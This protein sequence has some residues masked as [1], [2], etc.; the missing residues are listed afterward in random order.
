MCSYAAILYFKLKKKLLCI[1]NYMY[2]K[3]LKRFFDCFISSGE[4]N[5]QNKPYF[6]IRQGDVTP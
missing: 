4:K 1:P 5:S 6:F 3:P 2:N